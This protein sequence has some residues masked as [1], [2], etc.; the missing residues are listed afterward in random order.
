MILNDFMCTFTISDLNGKIHSLELTFSDRGVPVLNWQYDEKAK[1]KLFSFSV[2]I[3]DLSKCPKRQFVCS[4]KD[5]EKYAFI[6]DKFLISIAEEVQIDVCAYLDRKGGKRKPAVEVVEGPRNF[7]K[8][9]PLERPL[10]RE[11]IKYLTF[12]HVKK[13]VETSFSRHVPLLAGEH[14]VGRWHHAEQNS[15]WEPNN[16]HGN[17]PESTVVLEKCK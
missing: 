12:D 10:Y 1:D 13:K 8:F 2:W 9:V 4:P 7:L 3:V 17:L 16:N 15:D 5:N 14:K 11:M 6:P